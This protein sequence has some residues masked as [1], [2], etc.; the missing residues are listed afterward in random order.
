MNMHSPAV[1]DL[2]YIFALFAASDGL[3][4]KRTAISSSTANSLID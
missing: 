3:L 4:E 1:A 2:L